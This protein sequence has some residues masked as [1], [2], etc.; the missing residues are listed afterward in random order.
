MVRVVRFVAM[1]I[2]ALCIGT[3]HS[4]AA[5]PN[6]VFI[7]T[8]DLDLEYPEKPGD[9]WLDHYPAL[10]KSMATQGT[11]FSNHFV[12]NSLCCPSRVSMLR[13]QYAHN[14]GIFTNDP[15]DGGFP[16]VK[17]LELEKWT[18]ATWLQAI[19]YKTV[20]LG[21]YLNSY[22]AWS[23]YVP[24]G[25]TEWYANGGAYP[26]FNYVLNENGKVVRYGSSPQ[27]Y[28]QD[29]IRGKAVDFIL[30]NAA[31]ANRAPFFMWLAS[32]SPHEPAAYAPRHASAFPGAKAP[33]TP[34]FNEADVSR[35]PAWLQTHPLLTPAQIGEIDALYRNRLRSM[36]AVVETVDAIIAT[37][38]KTGDL[39]NTYIFFASDNGYHQGQHRLP[40]GKDTG[41]EEDLRVPLIVR[42]P[43]IPAGRVLPH[44]T[45]N[46]DLAPTFAQLAGRSVPPSVDGRSLVPLLR[47]SPPPTT[48]WRKAFL[49][50]HGLANSQ[51]AATAGA[52]RADTIVPVDPSSI[53]PPD[54]DALG[55]RTESRI[56]AVPENALDVPTVMLSA[57]GQPQPTFDGIHTARYSYMRLVDSTLQVY[58]LAN[59]PF[60]HVNIAT[61]AAPAVL[62]QLGKWLDSL[63]DCA[64]ESCRAAEESAP[65][66]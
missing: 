58:D 35:Q 43:G 20:L 26:Q 49:M 65:L 61:S 2:A 31:S 11:T 48:A 3:S 29:V 38:Q 28:L 37:L 50:E 19:G 27:D 8:D 23:L 5:R 4:Q 21:K 60:E 18:I 42:G 12:S 47:S 10:K 1:V 7:L 46:I 34:T 55:L 41:F 64:G 33:R 36:L 59:D 9:S 25:W 52:G 39:A 63:R 57:K 62:N 16:K 54:L 15:P 32:Y 44:M 45:V 17:A 14:T 6:I 40:G 22:S 56:L 66:Q 51:A 24:P 13:G 53:E 30:R